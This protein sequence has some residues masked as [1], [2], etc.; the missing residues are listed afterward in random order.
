VATE[1]EST[2]MI[3][4]VQTYHGGCNLECQTL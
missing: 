4:W 3:N 1:E 2:C